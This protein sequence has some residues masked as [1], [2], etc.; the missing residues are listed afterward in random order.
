MDS[1]KVDIYKDIMNDKFKKISPQTYAAELKERFF[2]NTALWYERISP[3]SVADEFIKSTNGDYSEIWHDHCAVCFKP[4][5]KHTAED[6]Y[7]SEDEFTP[8]CENCFE[9][10][11]VWK[12]A[13]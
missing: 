11:Q 8:L 9:E 10:M 3:A 4:I 12:N 5:D 6:F 1:Y 2:Q 13:K 7:L